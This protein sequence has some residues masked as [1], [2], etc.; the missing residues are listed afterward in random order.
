MPI[1]RD[2]SY[3]HAASAYRTREVQTASPGRLVVLVYDHV[4]AQLTRA[5]LAHKAGK[6]EERVHAV[7]KARAG[8]FELLATVD[9][10]RGGDVGTNLKSL[11]GFFLS[12]LQEFGL[13]PQPERLERI[14]RMVGDL[15]AAF[16]AIAEQRQ[17]TAA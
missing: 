9:A 3:Q 15:R 17:V 5:V 7:S 8:L 11:Y 14:T 6:I 13:R 2:M 12:E 4:I 10:E 1:V 16:A